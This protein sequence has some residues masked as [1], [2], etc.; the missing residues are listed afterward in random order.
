MCTGEKYTE[1]RK[2]L[3]NKTK[4]IE[5]RANFLEFIPK[6]YSTLILEHSHIVV[7]CGW[8]NAIQQFNQ[9][10]A[11]F[12]KTSTNVNSSDYE[13]ITFYVINFTLWYRMR[14]GTQLIMQFSYILHCDNVT[15]LVCSER[16]HNIQNEWNFW[17][18]HFYT[19]ASGFKAL[20]FIHAS[21]SRGEYWLF[22][23]KILV[24]E[25]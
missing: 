3:L 25:N 1:K 4:P 20:H 24:D 21:H 6:P 12:S 7:Y 22:D 16:K 11:I 2:K 9:C 14:N 8:P 5:V 19:K 10:I 18:N 15:H 13:F 23:K 17:K